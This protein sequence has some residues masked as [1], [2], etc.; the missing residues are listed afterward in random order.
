MKSAQETFVA[1]IQR[2]ISDIQNLWKRNRWEAFFVAA[3]III[4]LSFYLLYPV[5]KKND[6]QSSTSSTTEK[7]LSE[8]STQS[9]SSK[10][11]QHTEG[12]QS[13]AVN[14]APGGKA[15][16]NYGKTKDGITKK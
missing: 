3:I 9:E 12:D 1:R 10:I 14:V 6:V 13:P 5:I 11:E 4:G 15:T 2:E 8:I 16:I 7:S